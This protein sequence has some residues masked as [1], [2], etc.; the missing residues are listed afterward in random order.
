MVLDTLRQAWEP[1]V[2]VAGL[3]VVGALAHADRVFAA[4]QQEGV[5]EDAH[6]RGWGMIP[7][8]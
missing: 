3:L 2:L 8:A 1:F 4:G 6:A 7:R 5:A